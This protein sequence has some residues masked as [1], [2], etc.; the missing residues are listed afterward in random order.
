MQQ[1][2]RRKIRKSRIGMFA[3]ERSE[4]LKEFDELE[5]GNISGNYEFKLSFEPFKEM[6]FGRN[7]G[8]LIWTHIHNYNVRAF[9]AL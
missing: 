1:C 9:R 6:Y 5:F 7:M 8:I 2:G 4:L 3:I